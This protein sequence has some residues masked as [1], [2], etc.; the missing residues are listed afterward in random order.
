[1]A[2]KIWHEPELRNPFLVVGWPDVGYVGIKA[3]TYLKEKL[4]A[5]ELGEIE[6]NEFS[7]MPRSVIT[8]GFLEGLEFPQSEFSYW[9][10]E[11]SEQDIMICRS[12]QPAIRHYEFV[13]L[14]LDVAQK[15]GVNRIYTVGGLYARVHHAAISP[16]LAVI[17]TEKLREFVK[18]RG[19]EPGFDYHG[20]TSMN[21]LL[22]GVAKGRGLEGISLWGQVPH[23]L[24]EMPNPMIAQ[25]VLKALTRM[26]EVDIDFNEIE[27]EA[28][29]AEEKVEEMIAYLRGQHPEFNRY[30]ERLEQGMAPEFTEE[31]SRR[32]F[33]EIEEF[34]KR[35]GQSQ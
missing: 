20:P 25:A 2:V 34:L 26:L 5:R 28:K 13:N 15:F 8:D 6:L 17:N 22:I 27:A 23:Y 24:G 31:E 32:L 14:I 11:S 19:V 3:V 30:L 10:N 35:G 29:Y 1:M 12:D 18:S 9:I 4:G 7:L 16:V 21:G 33:K